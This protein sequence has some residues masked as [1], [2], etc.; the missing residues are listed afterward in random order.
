MLLEEIYVRK[1]ILGRRAHSANVPNV[2]P[3]LGYS[4]NSKMTKSIGSRMSKRI[5]EAIIDP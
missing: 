5:R 2:G 1:S 4:K 3:Y